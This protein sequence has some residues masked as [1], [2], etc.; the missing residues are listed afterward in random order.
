[1]RSL[2]RKNS[3]RHLWT[4]LVSFVT[5]SFLFKSLTLYA[6]NALRVHRHSRLLVRRI[7]R[8]SP[9]RTPH[10]IRPLPSPILSLT[11]IFSPFSP[12]TKPRP[13]R[14]KN[15]LDKS[16]PTH[17]L[18]VTIAPALCVAGDTRLYRV[19]WGRCALCES[20]VVHRACCCDGEDG[21]F[22]D[23]GGG[24]CRCGRVCWD[25]GRLD[26]TRA[27]GEKECWRFT[28]DRRG[29]KVSVCVGT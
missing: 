7:L 4:C 18:C 5:L 23:G 21:G 8:H 3:T 29:E 27:E 11:P 15:V 25:E 10:P 12:H 19:P 14:R 1:M 16:L 17:I 24:G 28:G 6:Y 20:G 9:R 26:D 2:A 22:G 13:G